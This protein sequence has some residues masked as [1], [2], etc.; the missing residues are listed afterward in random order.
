MMVQVIVSGLQA[1]GSPEELGRS[2]GVSAIPRSPVRST[3]LSEVAERVLD[4]ATSRRSTLAAERE[5]KRAN[6]DASLHGLGC[7]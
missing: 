3:S 2:R 4:L 6:V 1:D 5:L 7:R